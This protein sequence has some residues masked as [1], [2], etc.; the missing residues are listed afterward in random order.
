MGRSE[1]VEKNA[2]GNENRYKG[3]GLKWVKAEWG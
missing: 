3:E 2:G 1:E